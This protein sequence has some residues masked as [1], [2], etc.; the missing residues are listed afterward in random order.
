MFVRLFLAIFLFASVGS[1]EAGGPQKSRPLGAT[2]EYTPAD[3]SVAYQVLNVIGQGGMSL[4]DWSQTGRSMVTTLGRVAG[5]CTPY[6]AADKYT[7]ALANLRALENIALARAG[8]EISGSEKTTPTSHHTSVTAT[9]VS[10]V[11]PA[12][13]I[14]SNV[15]FLRGVP[16]LCVL[17]LEGHE[18][19][20]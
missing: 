16:H 8:T 1:S 2:F 18:Q 17:L 4:V 10:Y 7:A 15:V 19:D 13:G 12:R 11:G 6:I 14:Y 20:G 5:G 9:S 3:S